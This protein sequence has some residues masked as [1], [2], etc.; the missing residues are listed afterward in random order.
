MA[1]EYLSNLPVELLHHIFNYCDSKTI[2]LNIGS[3]CKRLRTVVYQYNQI[4]LE[5]SR[6]STSIVRRTLRYISR[7]AVKSLIL[8]LRYPS[9]TK[10]ELRSYMSDILQFDQLR[11]LSL[12]NL[13]DEY[14]QLFLES[15][16]YTQLTTLE[17]IIED[18]PTV[19][20]FSLLA[21]MTKKFNNLQKFSLTSLKH[22]IEDIALLGQCNITHLTIDKCLYS[23][24]LAVLYHVS[25]LKTLQ[26]N[27]VIMNV[28]N[29]SP[30]SQLTCL[31]IQDCCLSTEHL[32]LLISKTNALRHL[33]LT[34]RTPKKFESL[35]DI[36][37]WENFFR[38]ELNFLH[39][40]EFFISYELPSNDMIY[41]ESF[42]IP[43]QEPFWLTE[44]R[45]F[46]VCEYNARNNYLRYNNPPL[47]FIYT[48]PNIYGAYHDDIVRVRYG[49]LFK[50]DNYYIT[51]YSRGQLKNT[52]AC[53]VSSH[54]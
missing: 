33:K 11:N 27:D 7:H 6:I 12:R 38:T 31:I 51:E 20:T 42:L 34:F 37:D 25:S 49:I 19:K 2:F 40:F 44:K 14:L 17:I 52:T 32:K 8:S 3:V 43:F 5:F 21:S 47:I 46:V 22:K 53:D 9:A 45:W 18:K 15:L 50:R 26:L 35:G 1:D 29:S 23:E 28:D 13:R 39:R 16:N 54:T 24:Y 4:E 36:Y 41:F 48:M 30:I 10:N